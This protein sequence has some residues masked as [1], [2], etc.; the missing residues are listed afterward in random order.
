MLQFLVFHESY[1][2]GQI[3]LALKAA[4]MAL[5]DEVAG[6]VSW[7]VW[8]ARDGKGRDIEAGRPSTA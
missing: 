3:K 6:P 8:R 2:H 4:G 5:D 1:H 7:D